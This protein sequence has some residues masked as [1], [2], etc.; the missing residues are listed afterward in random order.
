MKTFTR[1]FYK[2]ELYGEQV[3]LSY[4]NGKSLAEFNENTLKIGELEATFLFFESLGM[5]KGLAQE[6]EVEHI[7][8]VI[9]DLIGEK[10]S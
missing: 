5:R 4:P 8:I 1:N 10:K 6:M 2:F 7:K 9:Q 3:S